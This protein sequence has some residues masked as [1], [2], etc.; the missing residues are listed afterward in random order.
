MASFKRDN[1]FRKV[2]YR[3]F[4]KTAE[5]LERG[6]KKIYPPAEGEF[7]VRGFDL[8]YDSMAPETVEEEMEDEEPPSKQSLS[9][10]EFQPRYWREYSTIQYGLTLG[11]ACLIILYDKRHPKRLSFLGKNLDENLESILMRCGA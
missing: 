10:Q 6:V 1:N 3:Q 8:G 11:N 7:H 5:N 2:S 9:W 4:M